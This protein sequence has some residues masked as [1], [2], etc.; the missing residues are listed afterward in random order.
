MR[1]SPSNEWDRTHMAKGGY[2]PGGG[3]PRKTSLPA[4]LAP[5]EPPAEAADDAAAPAAVEPKKQLPLDYML[6]VMRDPQVDLARRDRMAIAAAPFMH[7]RLGE[8]TNGKRED[9]AE[10]AQ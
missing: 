8:K 6:A 1:G 10:T 3:R 5:P 7:V 2:R 9:D 4:K